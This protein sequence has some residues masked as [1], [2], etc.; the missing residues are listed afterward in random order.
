MQESGLE[1][2]D[3]S[4]YWMP[5]WKGIVWLAFFL[6][7]DFLS[8]YLHSLYGYFVPC[9]L[10]R[11][12]RIPIM[13][14]N[15][16]ILSSGVLC[17]LS[18]QGNQKRVKAC[19]SNSKPHYTIFLRT[20]LS[21]TVSIFIL[22]FISKVIVGIKEFYGFQ[23]SNEIYSSLG[24][25]FVLRLILLNALNSAVIVALSISMFMSVIAT[26]YSMRIHI[27]SSFAIPVLLTVLI[28]E[29]ASFMGMHTVIL[30]STRMRFHLFGDFYDQYLY[31]QIMVILLIGTIG[32]FTLFRNSLTPRRPPV[33][34]DTSE[35]NLETGGN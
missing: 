19:G 27:I 11:L 28:F 18:I 12:Y 33:R 34:C 9:P 13:L 2:E 29:A 14:M 32:Y 30:F 24:L 16:F 26:R 31:Q 1:N 3:W 8:G 25:S 7:M 21:K 20:Y 5:Y 17:W 22:V 15:P 35:N 6:G 10:T 4:F 23:H